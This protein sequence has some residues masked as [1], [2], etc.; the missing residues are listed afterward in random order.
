MRQKILSVS[1][2]HKLYVNAY[3]AKQFAADPNAEHI[4]VVEDFSGDFEKG[5]FCF[6]ENILPDIE[7]I[8]KI[9]LFKWNRIYPA[10]FWFS[11]DLSEW[12]LMKSDVFKGNS[13]DQ[14]TME[15]YSHA[16]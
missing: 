15:V 10:D 2:G 9:I 5:A 12:Q 7:K 3:T 8:E 11:Y 14:I 16:E 13:H 4:I 1:A 6:V